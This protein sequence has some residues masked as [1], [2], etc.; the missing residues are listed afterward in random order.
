[1]DSCS[2]INLKLKG[3]VRTNADKLMHL[4][5]Q[6]CESCGHSI[7]SLTINYYDVRTKDAPDEELITAKEMEI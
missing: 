4:I 6:S 1:M 7:E 2:S 5:R 3:G